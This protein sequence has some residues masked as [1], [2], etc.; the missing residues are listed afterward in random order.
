MLFDWI[1]MVFAGIRM[2]LKKYFRAFPQI[3]F[4]GSSESR[5]L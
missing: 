3:I 1:R 4:T 2:F 5:S